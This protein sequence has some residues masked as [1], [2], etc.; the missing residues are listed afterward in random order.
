MINRKADISIVIPVYNRPQLV[1]R[2]LDS[3]LAQTMLPAHVYVVDNNST[4][5]T[6]ANIRRW[7]DEHQDSELNV[8]LLSEPKPGA[9][10]ARNRGLRE[11]S[12]EWVYFF[13]SDDCL[14]PNLIETAWANAGPEY[15]VVDWKAEQH[16]L[17]GSS[18]ILPYT[19]G[20]KFRKHIFNTQFRTPS[21]MSRTALIRSIGGWNE[22]LPAWNDWELGVRLIL[23]NPKIKS[24][25]QVLY[26]IYIQ[27]NS[28]T[29]LKFSDKR[30][31][32]EHTLD[33][34]LAE[35]P[36]LASYIAYRRAN[37]AAIYRR[38]GQPDQ[39]DKL[40]NIALEMPELNASQRLL[41]RLIYRYTAAG[42]RAAYILWR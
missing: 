33:T 36:Q 34:V 24:V 4:D 40:L 39:G 5:D 1:L 25:P 17:D 26:D 3:I 22:D 12:T 2:C 8:T 42:G 37:L 38:E 19:T 15:D 6:A 27:S 23:S 28:I 7:I 9:S 16:N 29:G 30:G 35:A 14:R 21:Y 32:W 13:D 20:N 18:R 11:V 41:L 10:A 31:A